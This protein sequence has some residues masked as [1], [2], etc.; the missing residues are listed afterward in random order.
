MLQSAGGSESSSPRN[1]L[2]AIVRGWQSEGP[3]V[4]VQ[5]DCGVDLTALVTRPA[6]EE[7]GLREGQRGAGP[8]QGARDSLDPSGSLSS[9]R[10]HNHSI[11][12]STA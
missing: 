7:L 3:L 2:E 10:V 5:L 1:R 12:G 9:G 6:W 8:D 4:R 11:A